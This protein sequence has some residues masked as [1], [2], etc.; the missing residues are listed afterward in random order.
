MMGNWGL[1]GF[2]WGWI[3]PL[4][5][6]DLVLKGLALWHSAQRREKWWFIALLLINSLGILPAIYLLTHSVRS[7]KK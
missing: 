3:L 1:P 6:L 2:W 4:V 5:I 7:K